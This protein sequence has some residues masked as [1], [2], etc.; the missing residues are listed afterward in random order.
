MELDL[1]NINN[2]TNFCNKKQLYEYNLSNRKTEFIRK[3]NINCPKDCLTVD[4]S[5]TIRKSD[6]QT[7]NEFWYKIPRNQRFYKISLFWD[8]IQPMHEYFEE[9]IMSFTDYLCSAGGLF[10][11]WFGTNAKDFIIW[12]IETQ[13][14]IKFWRK[15]KYY[16]I[17]IL[18]YILNK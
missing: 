5:Y 11:L 7:S 6:S 8:S 13:F 15:F 14:W 17:Q 4:Y 3:C 18:D 1:F 10:G 12:L 16:F 2:K 9:P